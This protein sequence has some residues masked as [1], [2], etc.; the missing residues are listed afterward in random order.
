[1]SSFSSGTYSV[2]CIFNQYLYFFKIQYFRL[3]SNLSYGFYHEHHKKS[4]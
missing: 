2:I 1:M 3:A 4:F